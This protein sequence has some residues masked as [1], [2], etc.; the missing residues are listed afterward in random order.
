MD[1]FVRVLKIDSSSALADK[2]QLQLRRIGS[3]F[4]HA[5]RG[6]AIHIA[7]SNAMCGLGVMYQRGLGPKQDRQEAKKW[8]R[9]A[10]NA[11]NVEAMFHLGEMYEQ[12]SASDDNP[13]AKSWFEQQTLE[14]YRRAAELGECR[15]L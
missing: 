15:H 10:A 1:C 13:K 7:G 2:A 12:D 6:D 11:G 14:M 9:S 5:A 8:F 3:Y 4:V